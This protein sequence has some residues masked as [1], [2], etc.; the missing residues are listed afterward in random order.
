[1]SPVRRASA[2]RRAATARSKRSTSLERRSSTSTGGSARS[3]AS[4]FLVAMRGP[5]RLTRWR[6]SETRHQL[7]CFLRKAIPLQPLSSRFCTPTSGLVPHVLRTLRSHAFAI[8]RARP[9]TIVRW[10]SA[11]QHLLGGSTFLPELASLQAEEV[12]LYKRELRA[13][14]ALWTAHFDLLSQL[15]ELQSA[16]QT[17]TLTDDPQERYARPKCVCDRRVGAAPLCAPMCRSVPLGATQ[18]RSS[19][20]L[21]VSRACCDCWVAAS[22]SKTA[23]TLSPSPLSGS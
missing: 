20:C 18:K 17:M 23:F 8:H 12:S 22:S 13:C 2:G 15:D 5:R 16:A 11:S 1:M 6:R 3:R 14:L 10:V 21:H 19:R 4:C 9:Q 7:Y